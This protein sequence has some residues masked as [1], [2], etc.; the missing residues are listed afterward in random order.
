MK[1]FISS[2]LIGVILYFLLPIITKF[3]PHYRL[4]IWSITAALVSFAVTT[5]MDKA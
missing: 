2:I 1:R 4:A 3:F 5:A